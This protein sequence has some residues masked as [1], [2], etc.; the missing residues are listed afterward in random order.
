MANKVNG[1]LTAVWIGIVFTVFLNI[2][3]LAYS[4][5]GTQARLDNLCTRLDRIEAQ[6]DQH[7]LTGL[8]K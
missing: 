1:K 8:M 6:L 7:V 3:G 5:G 4:Y 2:I